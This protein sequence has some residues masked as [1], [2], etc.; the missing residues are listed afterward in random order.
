MF[1]KERMERRIRKEKEKDMETYGK[2]RKEGVEH[3]Q[4][5]GSKKK[6]KND[7]RKEREIIVKRKRK[8]RRRRKKGKGK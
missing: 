4:R 6:D 5:K 7:K 3:D 8:D 1:Q 2:E